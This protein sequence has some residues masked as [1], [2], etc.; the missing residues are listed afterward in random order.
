M[1]QRMEEAGVTDPPLFLNQIIV[2]NGDV[3]RGAT[4]ADPS[5]LEPETATSP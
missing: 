1:T 3:C 2:H 4:E 5:Q